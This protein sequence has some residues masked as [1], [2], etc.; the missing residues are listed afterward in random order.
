M[1]FSL[2]KEGYLHAILSFLFVNRYVHQV[3]LNSKKDSSTSA[4]QVVVWKQYISNLG[5]KYTI[6]HKSSVLATPPPRRGSIVK[7]EVEI[8]QKWKEEGKCCEILYSGHYLT[9]AFLNS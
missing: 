1:N 7:K 4:F 2:F 6:I 8:T 3:T 5:D 9:I